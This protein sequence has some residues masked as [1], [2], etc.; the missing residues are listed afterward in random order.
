MITVPM[1]DEAQRVLY[2]AL[3]PNYEIEHGAYKD[4]AFAVTVALE[5]MIRDNIM[6]GAN[7]RVTELYAESQT[8][9]FA[10]SG[11]LDA[12]R[13]FVGNMTPVQLARMKTALSELTAIVKERTDALPTQ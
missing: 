1:L 8:L 10:L 7:L 9:A 13:R 5:P 4:G 6:M 11:N 2:E 12:A 3:S